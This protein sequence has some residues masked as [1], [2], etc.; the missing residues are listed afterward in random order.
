MNAWFLTGSILS[1]VLGIAHSLLGEWVG[2]RVLVKR[3]QGIA[4]FEEEEKDILGKRIV[5]LA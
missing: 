4:L 2:D 5:R 3:I 1:Y